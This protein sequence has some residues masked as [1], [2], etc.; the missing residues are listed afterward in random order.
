MSS[1]GSDPA[2]TKTR[3]VPSND[4][5]AGSPAK[6]KNKSAIIH[7]ETTVLKSMESLIFH[8]CLNYHSPSKF[9]AHHFRSPGV[10]L[11]MS[12]PGSI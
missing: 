3:W 11:G 7:H 9:P 1:N 4:S 6:E 10:Q 12:P 2:P 8:D 5:K